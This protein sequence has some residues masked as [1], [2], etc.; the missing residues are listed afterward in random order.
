ML[1]PVSWA[2][3]ESPTTINPSHFTAHAGNSSIIKQIGADNMGCII[4][5]IFAGIPPLMATGDGEQYLK[6]LK[7]EMCNDIAIGH[8][9]MVARI[10][11][12]CKAS[13]SIKRTQ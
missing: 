7:E 6:E 1:L 11:E 13:A 9:E 2:G 10:N 3:L 4:C 12:I 5:N 8:P